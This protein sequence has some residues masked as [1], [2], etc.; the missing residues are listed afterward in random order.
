[1]NEQRDTVGQKLC[2]SMNIS[3]PHSL[4]FVSCRVGRRIRR[5]TNA[6]MLYIRICVYTHMEEQLALS[7]VQCA[8]SP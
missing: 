6:G 3:F 1:M 7:S 8:L 2:S 5:R 4:A